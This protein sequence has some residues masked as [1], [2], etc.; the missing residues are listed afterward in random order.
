MN[1]LNS[2]FAVFV[3]LAIMACSNVDSSETVNKNTDLISCTNK[4]EPCLPD[5]SCCV[6]KTEEEESKDLDCH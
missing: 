1:N 6:V 2:L 3:L 5:H 4:G